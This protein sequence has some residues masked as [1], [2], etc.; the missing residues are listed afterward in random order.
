MPSST[1]SDHAPRV[2]VVD[3]DG[4]T[5][6]LLAADLLS[7][8]QFEAVECSSSLER[9]EDTLSPTSASLLLLSLR[10]QDLVS[11]A[12]NALKRARDRCPQIRS[13]VLSDGSR[14]ELISEVFRAGARGFFDREAYDPRLL[15]R[16]LLCVW[17]GQIWANSEQLSSVLESF[18]NL[19]SRPSDSKRGL[20]FLTPRERDVVRLVSLGLANREVAHELGLSAHTVKNYLFSAFDKIGV[21][22]RAELILY[23]VSRAATP[24]LS[25]TGLKDGDSEHPSASAST[26][27]ADG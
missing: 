27:R 5:A 16:C 26:P 25:E 20:E 23:V 24:S 19:S 6:R 8:Q 7:Q 12:V 13:I 11:D 22:S 18:A 4:V 17:A 1:R 15:S 9:F 10:R 21:S 3:A 2:L 14:Q